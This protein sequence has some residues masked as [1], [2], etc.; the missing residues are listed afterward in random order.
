MELGCGDGAFWLKN[1]KHWS[2]TWSIIF[3]DLSSGMLENTSK[4]L[5]NIIEGFY[6]F[7]EF[8]KSKIGWGY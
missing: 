7:F 1:K 4:K 6:R 3:S 5:Q 8:G 2:K